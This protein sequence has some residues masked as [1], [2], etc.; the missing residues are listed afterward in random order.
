MQRAGSMRLLL[1]TSNFPPA[2]GGIQTYSY[3]LARSL[4]ERV[5]ALDVVAPNDAAAAA[6]DRA[7]SSIQG[8]RQGREA[9]ERTAEQPP[10]AQL[11]SEQDPPAGEGFR[12]RR[13][14]S[15]GDDFAFSGILPLARLL[16][17]QR[18]DAALATHW[19]PAFALL[20][21]ARI[22]RSPLPVFVAAHGKELIIRP[23]ERV[24]LAQRA[25]DAVRRE[26]LRSAR[27]F[28]PVSERTAELLRA[29]GVASE[30]IEVVHNGVDP[31][32]F[33]PQPAGD[34]R[35]ELGIAG[36]MLLT[37]ARLV[38]RK[39]ID[40]VLYALPSLLART[41]ELSYVIV[42]DGADRER[43]EQLA[44]QLAVSKRVRFVRRAGDELVRY[45]NACDL[46]VMPAR[47]EP[48][49][50][51]GFGLVF[52]EAGACGKPVIGASAGGVVDAIVEGVTGQL[53]A[54]DDPDALSAA[55]TAL[56][57]DPER[58]ASLGRNG[59]ERVL[60]EATWQHAADKL[61]RALNARRWLR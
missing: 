37:V 41:P 32:R 36:P 9:L 23:F 5:C 28:F 17:E 7:A 14:W 11:G 60:R 50:I 25:Y 2:L 44:Q 34:L 58:A 3:E 20:L 40:T 10:G 57:A 12:L 38:R 61:L 54:A 42:G 22:R 53:V 29:S 39:G 21:A 31:R 56:L 33:R 51:E 48:G 45:Y 27:G 24:P 35:A 52:L 8:A 19:A 55:V 13:I 49:D 26:V 43:L 47:E 46:F 59:R 15:V 6:F 4:A 16:R 18:Y 1:V 30:R